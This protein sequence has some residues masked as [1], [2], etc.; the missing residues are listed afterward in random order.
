MVLST[1]LASQLFPETNTKIVFFS[2]YLLIISINIT[3]F[4][5]IMCFDKLQTQM[6]ECLSI[7]MKNKTT[8]LQGTSFH[9]L[10]RLPVCKKI[11]KFKENEEKPVWRGLRLFTGTVRVRASPTP[12]LLW[13]EESPTPPNL[14]REVELNWA[15]PSA[16]ATWDTL[17]A[18][19]MGKATPLQCP[20]PKRMVLVG[21]GWL[22][23][24]QALAWLL[25][26]RHLTHSRRV[27]CEHLGRSGWKWWLA[28]PQGHGTVVRP[29]FLTGEMLVS[30]LG[31][32]GMELRSPE[33]GAA[34]LGSIPKTGGPW[35]ARSMGSQGR[36]SQE[37][38]STKEARPPG[39]IAFRSKKKNYQV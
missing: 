31:D 25:R 5:T 12:R 3:L 4:H 22:S 37:R 27:G 19:L 24:W 18:G 10:D 30:A 38:A 8:H 35:E 13:R 7:C 2:S 16:A 23:S 11:W 1:H 29:Y 6:D 15:L 17:Q 9:I 36:V 39:G 33:Q 14:L 34:E 26:A 20:A 28:G 32:A 21:A